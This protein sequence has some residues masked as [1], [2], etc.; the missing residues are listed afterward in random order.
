MKQHAADLIAHLIQLPVVLNHA[1]HVLSSSSSTGSRF[2]TALTSKQQTSLSVLFIARVY[3]LY[4]LT[5]L[6]SASQAHNEQSVNHLDL[7]TIGPKFKRPACGMAAAAIDQHLL[8]APELSSKPANCCCRSTGQTDRRTHTR[9]FYD[10][11]CI[12]CR[13]RNK[14]TQH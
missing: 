9:P 11:F 12:L 7:L 10:T 3:K 14:C 8:L 2:N 5:C 6:L 13:P 4:L 1:V